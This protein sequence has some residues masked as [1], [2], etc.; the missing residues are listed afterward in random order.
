M[1][2]AEHEAWSTSQAAIGYI[3]DFESEQY[4][5]MVYWT[6]A[7]YLSHTVGRFT[8]SMQWIAA[9]V[10][11]KSTVD[12][13]LYKMNGSGISNPYVDGTGGHMYSGITKVASLTA[14]VEQTINISGLRSPSIF[15][16]M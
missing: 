12:C 10:K 6:G 15:L 2:I 13:E 5:S 7:P 11:I 16:L 3:I 4:G 8:L 1:I 9:N 14:N